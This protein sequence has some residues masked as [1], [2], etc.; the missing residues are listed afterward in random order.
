MQDLPFV[1]HCHPE[2]LRMRVPGCLQDRETPR[3]GAG[4]VDEVTDYRNSK[5]ELGISGRSE[6]PDVQLPR[7]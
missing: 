6:V 1:R 7:V 3:G 5:D 4:G 2:G